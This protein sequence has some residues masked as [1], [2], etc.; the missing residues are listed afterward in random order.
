MSNLKEYNHASKSK[1]I[2]MF[3][4]VVLTTIICLIGMAVV[5]VYLS[6]IK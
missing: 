3:V 2:H 4:T 1:L 5:E 6:I